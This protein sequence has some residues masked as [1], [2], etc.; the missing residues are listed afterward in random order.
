[1]KYNINKLETKKRQRF[2]PAGYT[3]FKTSIL[4]AYPELF[5]CYVDVHTN[6][7]MFYTRKQTKHTWYVKF[8]SW[9]RLKEKVKESVSV[10]TRWEDAKEEIK[11]SKKEEVKAVEV[12]QIFSCSW[13]YDQ[14]NVDFYQV[15]EKKGLTFTIQEIGCERSDS[16]GSDMSNYLTAVKDSFLKDSKPIKKRSMKMTSYSW[17]RKTD[18]KEKHYHSWYA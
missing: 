3:E 8:N 5:T 7:A 11:Q 4:D 17:L 13:G 14:T 12:G 10:L 6:S 1:M 16:G 15:T 9:D 18:T 2:I